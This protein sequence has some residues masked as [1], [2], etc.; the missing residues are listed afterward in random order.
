MLQRLDQDH[1]EAILT[2]ALEKWR[3]EDATD[4]NTSMDKDALKQLAIY[5]DG[6]GKLVFYM[7]KNSKLILISENC[8][9]YIGNCCKFITVK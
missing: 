4:F 5:S 7:K 6:D 8:I 9:K 2:R 1:I 3:G